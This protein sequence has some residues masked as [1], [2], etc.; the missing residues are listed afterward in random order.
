M[1]NRNRKRGVVDPANAIIHELEQEKIK[2]AMYSQQQRRL[3]CGV[4]DGDD[5]QEE[6]VVEE[7]GDVQGRMH[8]L[9]VE[10]EDEIVYED[11]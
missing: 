5:S 10:D 4:G 3:L 8:R 7:A 6:D 2:V 9:V 11:E 1:E